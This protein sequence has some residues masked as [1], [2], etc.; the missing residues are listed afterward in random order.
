MNTGWKWILVAS[1]GLVLALLGTKVASPQQL[2]EYGQQIAQTVAR[3]SI[4]Q[5]NVSYARGD[6][7]DNWQA[8]DVNIPVTLGDHLYTDQQS[9]AELQVH[10]G[11]VVRLGARTDL[12]ALNLTDDTRQ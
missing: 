9:R 11:D 12:T 7:P 10:G 5:G 8:A 1:A 6:D 2:D 4:V 3:V